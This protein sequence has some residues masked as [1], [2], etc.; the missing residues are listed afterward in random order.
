MLGTNANERASQTFD[1]ADSTARRRA[2]VMV[3]VMQRM[4]ISTRAPP[5]SSLSKEGE[6]D[7]LN[8]LYPS[9]HSSDGRHINV[10]RLCIRFVIVDFD[11]TDAGEFDRLHC[12]RLNPCR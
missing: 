5:N 6:N 8:M 12:R 4:S 11:S 1:A 3:Y 2:L 10:H 9:P 7:T